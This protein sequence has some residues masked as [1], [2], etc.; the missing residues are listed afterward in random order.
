MCFL[1]FSAFI[2][3]DSHD[4]HPWFQ[5]CDFFFRNVVFEFDSVAFNNIIDDGID[6]TECLVAWL[7]FMEESYTSG[8]RIGIARNVKYCSVFGKCFRFFL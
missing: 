6:V 3:I 5:R 2:K 7:F 8:S 4:A 1:F